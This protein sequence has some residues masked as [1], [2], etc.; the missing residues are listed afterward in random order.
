MTAPKKVDEERLAAMVETTLTYLHAGDARLPF[1]APLLIADSLAA[2]DKET[3]L[4]VVGGRS[5][6]ELIRA[7]GDDLKCGVV[8]GGTT[9]E[10]W[11][12]C[13]ALE[14]LSRNDTGRLRSF[15]LLPSASRRTYRLHQ[16]DLLTNWKVRGKSTNFQL[17]R[18]SQLV[19][20][21]SHSGGGV[22]GITKT[23]FGPN[24]T[25]RVY[26]EWKHELLVHP[27]L[28]L[29][30]LILM[31]V[32]WRIE[33]GQAG[34]QPVH[35]ITDSTGVKGLFRLREKPELGRRA[36]LLHWVREHFRRNRV[37][38]ECDILVRR[39]LRGMDTFDWFGLNGRIIPPPTE[40]D[41]RG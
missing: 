34:V 11:G 37:D 3:T 20:V 17:D 1:S 27:K 32:F 29:A 12:V 7:L 2:L 26:T 19:P 6:R 22:A 21:S 13:L 35:L 39:H 15:G 36:A 10:V 14:E 28:C 18:D 40:E 41:R 25:Y 33:L 16:L 23:V 31:R 9:N 8:C 24:N 38:P 5:D 4:R 30:S